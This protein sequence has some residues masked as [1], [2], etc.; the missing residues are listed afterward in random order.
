VAKKKT[1]TT[2]ARPVLSWLDDETD[3]PLIAEHAR[4]LDTFL[5]AVADGRIDEEELKAQERR[6]VA[7]MKDVQPRLDPELHAKVTELLCELVAYDLMQMMHM[8]CQ[9][10]PRIVFR[11]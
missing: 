1:K 6:L 11:G 9:S 7:V 2:A 5:A 4:R 10:R 8:F 3:Q